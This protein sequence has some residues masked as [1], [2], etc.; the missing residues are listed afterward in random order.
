MGSAYDEWGEVQE[1]F[2]F[3]GPRRTGRKAQLAALISY[4]RERGARVR[5]PF[6]MRW[7]Q[8]D[9]NFDEIRVGA[10]ESPEMLRL[11]KMHHDD[12]RGRK[13]LADKKLEAR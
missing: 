3:L 6:H 13:K 10:I 1:S 2:S 5:L 7:S 9:G 12:S 8:V 11:S 4:I